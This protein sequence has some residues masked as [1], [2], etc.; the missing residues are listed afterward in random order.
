[1]KITEIKDLHQ[2]RYRSTVEHFFGRLLRNLDAKLGRLVSQVCILHI[3]LD[4]IADRRN[5]AFFDHLADSVREDIHQ[6]TECDHDGIYLKSKKSNKYF[7]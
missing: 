4:H 6:G 1:M 5:Q 3:L 7:G 2:S